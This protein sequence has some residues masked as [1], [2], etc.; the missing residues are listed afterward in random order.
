MENILSLSVESQ[1]HFNASLIRQA[2]SDNKRYAEESKENIA[3]YFLRDFEA[4]PEGW[5]FAFDFSY[6]EVSAKAKEQRKN[7]LTNMLVSEGYIPTEQD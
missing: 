4:S 1:N 7:I 3:D 2:I 6:D 5:D